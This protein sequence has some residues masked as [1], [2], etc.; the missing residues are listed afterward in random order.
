[1][2]RPETIDA[3][4]GRLH[5]F[6]GRPDSGTVSRQHSRL[7][8][9]ESALAQ[10]ISW[11]QHE[12][13]QA[14]SIARE[15]GANFTVLGVKHSRSAFDCLVQSDLRQNTYLSHR[16][17][18]VRRMN[19]EASSLP[20]DLGEWSAVVNEVNAL[21]AEFADAGLVLINPTAID[22]LRFAGSEQDPQLQPLLARRWTIKEPYVELLWAA[23]EE[24]YEHTT[25]F[26]DGLD[27]PDQVASSVS[28]SLANRIYFDVAFR[29]H[30]IVEHTPG[31]CVYRPFF[32]A[33]DQ[34]GA[35]DVSQEPSGANWSGGVRPEIDHWY[36]KTTSGQSARRRI[37]FVHT[38]EEVRARIVWLRDSDSGDFADT[39]LNH[40][41]DLLVKRGIP[42]L[43]ADTPCRAIHEA[44]RALP[45]GSHLAQDP[46]HAPVQLSEPIRSNRDALLDALRVAYLAAMTHAFTLLPRPPDD[47]E[48]A[49][50]FDVLVTLGN[51]GAGGGRVLND[52]NA[53]ARKLQLFFGGRLAEVERE[54]EESQFWR[55]HEEEF[56]RLVEVDP[57]QFCCERLR[58]PYDYIASSAELG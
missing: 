17:S 5:K 56:Q 4:A 58:L 38:R 40:L 48:S 41:P 51:E 54:A 31:L 25:L 18:E 42:Q 55:L 6:H 21:H 8:A 50:G 7:E 28:R 12:V 35:E 32:Q 33:H 20:E 16:I 2:R 53:V 11:R 57:V 15:L 1:M 9:V 3:R 10:L 43:D 37:A 46:I 22:E 30:V 52:L 39:M 19:K 29:D 27:L 14:E 44:L 24:E 45:A 13:L 34:V 26:V 49:T 23:E 36:R 47:D